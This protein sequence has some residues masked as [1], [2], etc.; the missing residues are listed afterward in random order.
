MCP[1]S[2]FQEK[3]DALD[4]VIN[5]LKEH[6]K[7]L[8]NL[9]DRLEGFVKD[10]SELDRRKSLTPFLVSKTAKPM[11][12][13]RCEEWTDFNARSRDAQLVAFEVRERV[14]TVNSVSDEAVCEYSEFLPQINFRVK[15]E[16]GRYIVDEI[17][18]GNLNDLLLL[19][20][21]RL[22]CGLAVFVK[23]SRFD[24]SD[25]ERVVQLSR[26]VDPA[27]AKRWLSRELNVAE[28]NIVLGKIVH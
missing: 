13:V 11:T 16:D 23:S 10:I 7:T 18:V 17:S 4:L 9:A 26:Q 15:E 20:T 6:E 28:E 25:K 22:R 5:I 2:E 19:F 27:E 12:L 8:S 14:F 1:S 21:G 24:L 3:V